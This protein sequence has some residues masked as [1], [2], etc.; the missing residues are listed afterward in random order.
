MPSISL[1]FSKF[2]N[3]DE[4]MQKLI[5]ALD[6]SVVS[7]VD[8]IN[9]ACDK[10]LTTRNKLEQAIY[11]KTSVFNQFTL[12]RERSIAHLKSVL[13][14][15]LAQKQ[16]T[17]YSGFTSLLI[18]HDVTHVLKVLVVDTK[19]KRIQRAAGGDVSEGEAAKIVRAED[20]RAY[21]WTDFLFQK[22]AFDKAL[23]D[24]VIPVEE[25]STDEVV[26]LI[27]ENFNK[28]A[29]L[30]TEDSTQAVNDLALTAEVELALLSKGQK[31]EVETRNSRVSLKVNKSSFSFSNLTKKLS[32]IVGSV[33]GV[34]GV[35]VLKGKTYTTSV[36][37]D[38]QF[39]LPPKVLLVDDER[40]YVE[41]LSERLVSRNVGSYAVFDGQEALDFIDGDQPDVMVLD[42]KMPGINGIE[43]LQQTKK[44][45][46]N[47][48]VII[49][50]GHGSEADRET[51]MNLGAY[52]YL[53][54]PTDVEKLSSTINEAY[55]K[56]AAH[57][58]MA[59]S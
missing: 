54:K 24:I 10:N 1:F 40:E 19:D 37:R 8:I 12:E 11:Q 43:V 49:L 59:A 22:E 51:C 20:I 34:D 17:L 27:K 16:N 41:T 2:T 44:T 52:A 33:H 42:L 32:E 28:T 31:V 14:E 23:Y 18:P 6:L 53:Q 7:D 39:E 48:E 57:N 25:K 36:Y 58:Q 13:A 4:I 26:A 38:Q 46:P 5:S 3:E 47:I 35:E 50:T 29:V 30:E 45:N 55:K 9:D 15:R 21:N 56:I